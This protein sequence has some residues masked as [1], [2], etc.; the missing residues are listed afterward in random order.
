MRDLVCAVCHS[1]S[2]RVRYSERIPPA[3]AL[4][5]SARR[6]PQKH[7]PR[8]VECTRCGL[9]YSNPYFDDSVLMPLYREATYIDESQLDQMAA[10]YLRVFMRSTN[11]LDSSARIMEIGC[12][13]GFFLEK[14]RNAGFANV[15]GVEPGSDA[16]AK[17]PAGIRD[18]IVND[19]FRTRDFPTASF[20]VVCC[21]QVFDHLPDPN[22]FLQGIRTV[23]RPGGRLIAINHNIRAWITKLLGEKS[24]MYDIEH[25]C[26]FDRHTIRRLFEANGFE[27]TRVS[28]LSNSYSPAYAAKMLPLP[29]SLKSVLVPFLTRSGVRRLSL[30][31]PAGNMLTVGCKRV[32]P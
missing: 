20:D 6:N 13:N 7:H 28:G 16:V 25:I 5:F 31:I 10:D 18:R 19:F 24:P 9:I 3:A 30:R 15:V 2:Y 12:G 8:I 29:S 32:A 4:N 22:G 21:F 23:L 1:D 17:A 11:S 27:V 26:L 14:L